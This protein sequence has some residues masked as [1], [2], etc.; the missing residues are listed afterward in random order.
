M[1]EKNIVILGAG[2]GGLT[3][4]I[5]LHQFGFK[6]ISIY[7]RR[8]GIKTIGAG[9]VLWANA[10]KILKK[11]GLLQS[12]QNI[13]GTVQSMQRLTNQ[14]E[15]IGTINAQQIDQIIGTPSIP[16]SRSE[17]QN[18]LS[19][20]VENLKIPVHYGF[21]AVEIISDNNSTSVHFENH[22][23]ISPDII[24][25]ADGRMKSVAREFVTGNN[26]PVYQNFVNWIGILETEEPLISEM[27]I[28]D[29]W[30]TGE[31]F[32][33][34][35]IN[36]HKAYWAGGKALPLNDT[37][38]TKNHQEEL[39]RL[40]GSWHPDIN[41]I[42][43]QTLLE[44]IKYIEVFDHNP[45]KNWYKANVC[46]IGDA[47]HAALPTSGQG[48]C[49]AIED[50]WHIASALSQFNHPE[51]AFKH[52]QAMRF[53]KTTNITMAGRNLA[54]SLFNP[55]PEFCRQ[56]NEKA[57]SADYSNAGKGIGELWSQNLPD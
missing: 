27:N 26:E 5:A 23:K 28:R 16:V 6:N 29:F 46:L 49:Q 53:D 7:E 54:S 55:N 30:G 12:I 4:A 56:R 22:P 25:G 36:Q 15:E 17:L 14:N 45:V 9:L 2:V 48:A 18:V 31:R 20:Y 39:I 52:F 21:N 51:E 32:G 34:V 42:V 13:G 19:H 11:L 8:S 37:L 3:T 38:K 1:K 40:F 24:I 57:M 50:A 33:I 44:N 43:Q 10:T 41:R 35:P 47:A